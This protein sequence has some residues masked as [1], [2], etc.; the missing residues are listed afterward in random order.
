MPL[1]ADTEMTV[2]RAFGSLRPGGAYANRDSFVIGK[3]G[4][5]KKVYRGVKDPGGHAG[6][7]LKYVK[8]NLAK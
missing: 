6:D 8:E 4:N 1:L 7:V 3:D 2:A 5:I